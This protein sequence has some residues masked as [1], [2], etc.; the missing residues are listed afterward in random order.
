[1]NIP[2]VDYLANHINPHWIKITWE[3]LI[4]TEWDKTGGDEAVFYG[5]EWDQ[6]KDVWKNLTTEGLG[7]ILTFN[8]TSLDKPF[9]SG[10]TIKLRAYAKNGVG[11]GEYSAVH[12]I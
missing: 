7:K 9:A 1:M 4:S 5:L 11:F 10:C 12:T 3:P 2:K 6:A 8:L